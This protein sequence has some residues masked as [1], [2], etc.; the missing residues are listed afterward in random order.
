MTN[1]DE[2]EIRE[3]RLIPFARLNPARAFYLKSY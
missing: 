1:C 2:V 3:E